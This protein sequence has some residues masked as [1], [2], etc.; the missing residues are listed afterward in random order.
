MVAAVAEHAIGASIIHSHHTNISVSPDAGVTSNN[1]RK[2]AI[3]GDYRTMPNHMR[4]IWSCVYCTAPFSNFHDAQDHEHVCQHRR[5]FYRSV[6]STFPFVP[7]MDG[8]NPM[9]NHFQPMGYSP[10]REMP[11]RNIVRGDKVSFP[12]MGMNED[13]GYMEE[14]DAAA[15]KSLELFTLP[16]FDSQSVR[17]L[18]LRCSFCAR[19][20]IIPGAVT[21]PEQVE[22]V[23]KSVR[24]LAQDHLSSCESAPTGIKTIVEQSKRKR[25][26]I[27]DE[28]SPD[29]LQEQVFQKVLQDFCITRCQQLGIVTS[30][31][32]NGIMLN[33]E[34]SFNEISSELK[35]REAE[36]RNEPAT[37]RS[38][39]RRFSLNSD[40]PEDDHS[41]HPSIGMIDSP[42]DR[43]EHGFDQLEPMPLDESSMNRSVA[44][45][46]DKQQMRNVA[47]PDHMM[48][49]L[50][51]RNGDW[52]CRYCNHLPPALRDDQY[53]WSTPSK[54][55]PIKPFVDYHLSLCRSYNHMHGMPVPTYYDHAGHLSH[56]YAGFS[57]PQLGWGNVSPNR[58]G[59]QGNQQNLAESRVV[60]DEP[61]RVSRP[62]SGRSLEGGVNDS[63]IDLL[64]QIDRSVVDVHGRE[65]PES[66]RLVVDEDRLL[67]TDYFFF[68][69]KQLRLVRFTESDRRTRGGKRENIK[70]GYGGLE[71]VHCAVEGKNARK[72]FWSDVD[73]L[74][75]SFAEIPA[76]VI[77]CRRCP[78]NVKNALLELKNNHK[79]Q[80]SRLPRGSQKVFFRRMWRRLHDDDPKL[81]DANRKALTG[82]LNA[83]AKSNAAMLTVNVSPAK[84]SPDKSNSSSDESILPLVRPGAEAATVLKQAATQD[85]PPSPSSRVLLAMP[86]DK[87]WLSDTDCFIRRQIEVFAASKEDVRVATKERKYHIKEGQIGI[88][89]VHCAI[90]GAACMSA[91]AYPSTVSGIYES[92]REFQRMHLENCKNLPDSVKTELSKMQGAA[93]LSSVLRTYYVLSAHSLGLQDTPE[94]IRTGGKITPLGS[95]SAVAFSEKNLRPENLLAMDTNETKRALENNSPQPLSKKARRDEL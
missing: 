52:V 40:F 31:D 9:G 78:E 15:C 38:Y 37:Y 89:C 18:A 24:Q 63:A 85:G 60:L 23:G 22:E 90:A 46:E 20:T 54:V 41:S 26:R 88:R 76:H 27:R 53:I 13:K 32:G 62:L 84:E 58:F 42:L 25:Q 61:Q 51:E 73:R 36:F 49:F 75:N 86:E 29:W 8:Y 82:P 64:S 66:A 12:L 68:L 17:Q 33:S 57:N 43:S 87:E 19:G 59:P 71:C 67:L 21:I 3:E 11:A 55:P 81:M 72:F 93:S 56:P 10:Q 44:S 16:R 6:Q 83:F 92:V 65:L 47:R 95:F 74:A 7:M 94:G 2:T 4:G 69:M 34:R 14:A 5:M 30:A 1:K 39:Q 45:G 35:R 77:K 48:P 79:E 70:I 80:M 28:S 50:Q 91:V